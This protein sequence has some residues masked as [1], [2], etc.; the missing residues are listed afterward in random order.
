[1]ATEMSPRKTFA[2]IVALLLI[3][4]AMFI[5][6]RYLSLGQRFEKVNIGD[7][8]A[9][10]KA[11]MGTPS[12]EA[13]TALYFHGDREYRYFVTPIPTL[14][15]VSFKDGKVVAKDKISRR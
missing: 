3:G 10:V 8:L 2:L 13:T 15:V 6:S 7:D 14:W 9:T 11:T 4:P 12:E 5:T 1:M